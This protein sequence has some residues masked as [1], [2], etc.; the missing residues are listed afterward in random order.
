VSDEFG[1]PEPRKTTM[2]LDRGINRPIRIGTRGSPL[3]TWQAGWVAERLRALH[4]A[5]RVELVEIKTQGDR[6]RTSQLAAIG[7]VGLFTKE[8]QR[9]VLDGAA[10]LAVHSLKDLPTRVTDEL[11]L[12]AVP[13]REDVA[14]ALVAPRYRTIE[15]LP[16]G[17][18]VGTSSPRR[19][20]QLLYLRPDLQIATLRGNV[21]TRLNQASQ[22]HLDAVVLASAGLRRLRLEH[23]ITER[24]G[25]PGFLPA[26][27]QGALGIECRRDDA[28]VLAL[29]EPLDD[30]PSRRA[31]CAERAALADLE[32]GCS[33]PVAA[34]ARDIETGDPPSGTPALALTAAVF[35][36]DGR[37]RVTITLRGPHDDP[38]GLGRSVAAALR[39]QGATPLLE[40]ARRLKD[41]SS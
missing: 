13:P 35:D 8:I 4:P 23:Q 34:W 15:A 28:T 19:R 36:P 31:V 41:R 37:A 27:G 7:E 33:L 14:D 17:A 16:E 32:G 21:E 39:S 40:R 1:F 11:I 29:L 2:S 12:A 9:A 38:D 6:D 24:L 5:L 30:P 3:A 22:G 20:A 26:V 10:D 25:P 18:K